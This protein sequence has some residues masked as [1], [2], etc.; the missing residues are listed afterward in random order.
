VRRKKKV[1][2]FIFDDNY[3]TSGVILQVIS[4]LKPQKN[5]KL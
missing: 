5:K 4:A 2:L 1:L 3:I